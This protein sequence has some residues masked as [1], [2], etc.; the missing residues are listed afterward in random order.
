MKEE[1][2]LKTTDFLEEQGRLVFLSFLAPILNGHGY[3][4]KEVQTSLEKRLDI[5]ITFFQHRYIIELKRWYGKKY[6]EQGLDQ[7]AAYLEIHGL[8]EGFL[9]IFDS[10][11][12]RTWAKKTVVHKGKK[13]FMVWV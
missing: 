6:H 13:I 11:K 5:I 8:S 7:L 12:K 3:S 10:R 2:S 9:I 1:H 4:F